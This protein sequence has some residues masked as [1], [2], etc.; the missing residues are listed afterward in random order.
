MTSLNVWDI[1]GGIHPPE[2]KELSNR[3]P[4]QRM[5]LPA[6]LIVPLA[7]HLG[8]PAEPCVTLGEQVLKGQLIAEASGFV[9]APVHAPTSGTVSFIGPQ[10][11][12]HVSGMT[13]TAIVIDSDGRDQWI[14]LQPHTDYRQLPPAELLDIIRQAGINGLGGAGFPTAVKLTAP[15]TQTIRALIINGTECEPY[16]TAD[17][18]L[19]R[20]KAAELVAGIEIL[21]YLIQPQQVLIGIEDNKPEAIAAV[22]AAIGE[23]PY[24][25]KVF[26][27][28]YPSGGE[29]Q[30][31]QILTGEEVP[32]GGLPADIGMLCQNVGTCVAVH[33]AVLLGKPLISRI[34]TLTG[35]AL[36][37]PMNVE[38]LIG[39]PVAELLAFAGL[40]SGKLNRL[41]MGGP[42]MGFTLPSMDVPLI[43]TTNCLLASTLAEL[44][45]PPPALPC[46]RCGECAEVC[47]AS[48]LP[49]QLHFFALGQEHEQ[50]K[51]YNLFDCIECGACAYVC[52][53]SI[54][55]VQYYRAAKGE[56]RALEQKQQKAEHSR[57]RFEWRQE[58]LRRAEEQKEADRK[59]RAERAARAKQAQAQTAGQDDTVA[60]V[61]AQK[62][63]LSEEQKKLKIEASMAQV[64]LKKAEKQLAAHATPELEAQVA[65]LRIAASHA[66]QALDAA[67]ASAPSAEATPAPINDE[68]AKKAKIEAAMLRAQVRKLEKLETRDDEQEAELT[69][70][71]AQLT[72]AEQ[73]LAEAQQNAP[74]ASAKPADDE[75]LKKAKIEA[76][77]LR[78]QL[79][80]LEKLESRDEQ[81]QAELTRLQAQLADAEQALASAQQSAPAAPSKP[82]GDE[83]LKKAKIELA[84]KRAELKKAEKAGADE[85]ELSKLRDG[86]ASAEQALHAAEEKSAKPAPELVRTD[87]RP[88]DEQAR[89]LKTEVAFAR[90][91]LRKLERDAD[92]DAYLVE[93]ARQRL[94]EAERKLQEHTDS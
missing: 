4:I 74:V 68:A 55:L 5:P 81:Q 3:A 60:P 40:D 29:K 17:D 26:P 77:M 12:P 48:L 39:T 88:I 25:L 58:R 65:E 43:K 59:A 42:M 82:A 73:A 44:P 92:S 35:E 16:I 24:V 76:A 70:L 8:A 21:E 47:P 57:Q 72:K 86:L 93:A 36:A 13:A 87:K 63:G 91:D 28:K 15:P 14:E 11:Y 33:D 56:I 38:A 75:A 52:P 23:R 46:I 83:A 89:A 7:Q 79:R 49:Q 32:S 78:A 30:L 27:T 90:A 51:A 67:N 45:P 9:S 94:N 61:Q 34:T 80:K 53:S 69:R 71:Q 22:R 41:I 50:L 85:A 37:R 64:A 84:M 54:P 2:R 18:L 20:E 66:Q 31:I 62:A 6:R 10:P 1:H 19:M